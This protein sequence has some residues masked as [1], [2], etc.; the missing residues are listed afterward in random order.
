MLPGNTHSNTQGMSL[1]RSVLPERGTYLQGHETPRKM[2]LRGLVNML[3]HFT[4]L[5]RE[6]SD[7]PEVQKYRLGLVNE[8]L[9]VVS[10][11]LFSKE[12]PAFIAMYIYSTIHVCVCFAARR[13]TSMNASVEVYLVRSGSR[14]MLMCITS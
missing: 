14:T 13:N 11:N 1:S 6:K 8:A 7:A 3:R 5:E 10:W 12:M 9:R 4:P 2:A